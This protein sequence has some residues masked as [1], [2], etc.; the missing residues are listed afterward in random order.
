MIANAAAQTQ[1]V[2]VSSDARWITRLCRSRRTLSPSTCSRST[3]I[4]YDDVS[5]VLGLDADDFSST[6]LSVNMLSGHVAAF[7]V[8]LQAAQGVGVGVTGVVAT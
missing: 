5:V 2:I 3:P 1:Y 6:C 8:K 7:K 4:G